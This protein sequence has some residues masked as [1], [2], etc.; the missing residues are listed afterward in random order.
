[1]QIRREEIRTGL[2]VVVAI[3][4][5]TAVL[6]ALAAPG[7]FKP[8]NT[9]RIFFDNAGGLKQGAPVLLAGRKIG[10]VTNLISPVPAHER[11][12][13]FPN[14]EVLVE[15][16]VDRNAQIYREI[17]ARMLAFTM[18]SEQVIDFSSG[19]QESGLAPNGAYFVGERS[20]DFGE[21]IAEAVKVMKDV[22]TP[23]AAEAQK[24]MQQLNETAANLKTMTQPGSNIDQAVVKFR[25]L[26]NNL[27]ILSG[28]NGALQRSLNSMETLLGPDGHLHSTLTNVDQMT[29]DLA[30]NKDLDATLRNFR[31]SSEQLKGTMSSLTPQLDEAG[32]NIEQFSDT[33]KREPWRL[34]WKTQKKYPEDN[35]VPQ[36]P[37]QR[38]QPAPPRTRTR[39]ASQ[40][41]SD[42][43]LRR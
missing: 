21:S 30:K 37:P 28:S 18:L 33:V 19:D 1:M 42:A 13:K 34:I 26:G 15:V 40:T 10:Q 6:L 14:Y 17:H 23:V 27:V 4:L 9:Y 41:E 7:V 16:R 5:L 12:P 24:T 35:A 43:R 32:H 31:Q 2:L 20:K 29:S 11:P 36:P 3:G 25:D 8:V 38:Q 39:G 22:V